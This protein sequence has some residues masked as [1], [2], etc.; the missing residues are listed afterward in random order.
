MFYH[1]DFDFQNIAIDFYSFQVVRSN[2][3]QELC[4]QKNLINGKNLELSSQTSAKNVVDNFC[5]FKHVCLCEKKND[6]SLKN[7]N[8]TYLHT[9]F[10][11]MH[12]GQGL[13]FPF[14]PIIGFSFLPREDLC[15]IVFFQRFASMLILVGLSSSCILGFILVLLLYW[16]P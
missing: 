9:L 6:S 3:N 4:Y 12:T 5:Q 13:G 14:S 8:E 7:T 10:T 1:T 11:W 2:G 16:L 15:N